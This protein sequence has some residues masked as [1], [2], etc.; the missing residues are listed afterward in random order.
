MDFDAKKL[1]LM[2]LMTDPNRKQNKW[3]M[4]RDALEEAHQQGR[5]EMK[6]EFIDL[7]KEVSGFKKEDE[8]IRTELIELLLQL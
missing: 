4:I 2:E 3:S 7:L 5:E 6:L 8:A 1:E